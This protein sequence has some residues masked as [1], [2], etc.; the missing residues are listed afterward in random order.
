MDRK[1]ELI[2]RRQEILN[3]LQWNNPENQDKL[4]TLDDELDEIEMEE[5]LNSQYWQDSQ[6][7]LIE[8]KEILEKCRQSIQDYRRKLNGTS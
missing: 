7:L 8:S 6:R 3:S 2:A 4:K 5:L 1:S